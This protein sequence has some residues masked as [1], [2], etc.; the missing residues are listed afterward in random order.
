MRA[1][2]LLAALRMTVKDI[3]SMT[4]MMLK[5]D[6]LWTDAQ[7]RRRLR[8]VRVAFAAGLLPRFRHYLMPGYDPAKHRDPEVMLKWLARY[9]AGED[10][11]KLPAEA[12]DRL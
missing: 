4:Q 2:G 3:R 8:Q 5:A 10:L 1:R 9:A 12:L 6:G 7:S 11:R